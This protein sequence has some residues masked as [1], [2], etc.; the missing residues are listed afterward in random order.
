MQNLNPKISHKELVGRINWQKIKMHEFNRLPRKG[1]RQSDTT[2]MHNERNTREW[3][4]RRIQLLLSLRRLCWKIRLWSSIQGHEENIYFQNMLWN[5]GR[6]V[7]LLLHIW[8][9]ST[10][11]MLFN[12][13]NEKTPENI[14]NTPFTQPC[15]ARYTVLI[16][17]SSFSQP[18]QLPHN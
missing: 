11:P 12:I 16:F 3:S 4:L 1:T 6:S 2:E 10:L 5:V 8:Q 9:P 13:T 15:I 18:L 14:Q 7:I 17:N